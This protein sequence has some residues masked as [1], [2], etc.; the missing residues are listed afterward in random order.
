MVIFNVQ[1]LSLKSF[2]FTAF[3]QQINVS[4]KLHFQFLESRSETGLTAS[5]RH[6]EREISRRKSHPLRLR[7]SRKNLSDFIISF[8]VSDR[9][10]S[11]GF[12]DRLLIQQSNSF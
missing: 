5:A 10:G 12:T 11:G 7:R 2:P 9:I 4:E 3:A 1:D 8:D 6:I